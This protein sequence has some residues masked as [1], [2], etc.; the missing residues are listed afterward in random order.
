MKWYTLLFS[1]HNSFDKIYFFIFVFT[2]CV[3]VW[4]CVPKSGTKFTQA[5]FQ[6]PCPCLPLCFY[7]L[8][9]S[10]VAM[11][12]GGCCSFHIPP[13]F[14]HT[15]IMSLT[16]AKTDNCANRNHNTTHTIW[17]ANLAFAPISEHISQ[18]HHENSLLCFQTAIKIYG[19][20]QTQKHGEWEG[21]KKWREGAR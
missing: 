20:I 2:V 15:P 1:F 4:V 17:M 6:C 11:V 12:E 5:F 3:S 13:P 14:C 9:M 8:P 10:F 16:Y 21:D 7:L 18:Q 19:S